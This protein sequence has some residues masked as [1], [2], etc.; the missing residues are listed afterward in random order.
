MILWYRFSFCQI[1]T[2]IAFSPALPLGCNIGLASHIL[3]QG[4]FCWCSITITGNSIVYFTEALLILEVFNTQSGCV[5]GWSG[6]T[7]S[8]GKQRKCSIQGRHTH[9]IRT[10]SPRFW[11]LLQDVGEACSS[12]PLSPPG[13]QSFWLWSLA[14]MASSPGTRYC[15]FSFILLWL[16][17]FIS[18]VPQKYDADLACRPLTE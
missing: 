16:M 2:T 17:L 11:L 12:P 8:T 18:H 15:R 9:L 6:K 14:T 10:S 5:R 13:S 7:R 3:F 4:S 1:C